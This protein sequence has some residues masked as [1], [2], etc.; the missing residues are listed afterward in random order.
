MTRTHLVSLAVLAVI[1]FGLCFVQLPSAQAEEW[2]VRVKPKG[3]L[4][5]VDLFMP[6]VSVMLG[7][8]EGLVTLDEENNWIPC[9]AEDWRWLD[10]RTIEFK[11]RRG[12]TFHNGERFS[13]ESVKINWHEYKK[14]ENSTNAVANYEDGELVWMENISN[15][16]GNSF[17]IAII[18]SSNF[19]FRM[20]VVHVVEPYIEP[21]RDKHMYDDG[22]LCL[23]HPD[24]FSSNMSIL[25][26]RNLA[27]SWCECIDVYIATGTWPAAEYRH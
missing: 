2:K 17:L 21:S 14:M 22:H 1:Q 26:F 23:M 13:S 9:L 12:V 4:R 5:V 16:Y 25:D 10:G 20:P 27:C 8:A 18:V 7:Y 19:P 11:L 24:E 3:T 15:N 6:A